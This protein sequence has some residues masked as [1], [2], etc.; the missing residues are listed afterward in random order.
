M[1]VFGDTF[2]IRFSEMIVE[3]DKRGEDTILYVIYDHEQ[4]NWLIRG[5]SFK[6]HDFSYSCDTEEGLL[7]LLRCLYQYSYNFQ[8]TIELCNYKDLPNDPDEITFEML[9]T[10]HNA[11]DEYFLSVFVIDVSNEKK[12]KNMFFE[13]YLSILTDFY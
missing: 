1:A 2:A 12:F 4:S 8:N 3:N 10:S 5:K 11:N 6:D 13:S 7:N 9:E